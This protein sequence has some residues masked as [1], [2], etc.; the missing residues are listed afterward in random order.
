MPERALPDGALDGL[1]TEAAAR[2]GDRT[3]IRTT[4]PGAASPSFRELDAAATRC[5]AAVQGLIGTDGG[6]VAL[7]SPLD[8]AF[9]VAFHGI[10][11]SG[12]AVVPVNPL[13]RADELCHLLGTAR[14]RLA[15]VTPQ[16]LE[17][18]RSVRVR[19]P[20][21]AEVLVL[22]EEWPEGT[23]V[24]A[25]QPDGIACL[26]FT[27]GTTG[28]PKAAVLTHRNLLVNAAQTAAA[29]RLD[30]DAVVLNHLPKYHLMHLNSALSAGATQVLCAEPDSVDA[31]RAAN[32]HRATH[33]YSIPMRLTRLAADERLPQLGLDTVRMIA[34][35]GSALPPRS[36]E[37]LRRHF[38]VPVFQ[39]YGLAETSP[40]T[41]SDGPD[42][43]RPGSVGPPVEGTECRV[44]DIDTG[45]VLP[46]GS[47]GEVQVRGPQ[48]M[49]GY[50]SGPSPV[51]AE[52][53]LAT[54]D[55][56]V[57][58]ED[59]YLFLVDRIK[60]VFKCDNYLVSP[61]EVEKALRAHPAVRDCVVVDL[62]DP[63]SGAVA[64]AF[65]VLADPAAGTS[66]VLAQV[67]AGLPYYQRVRHAERTDAIP[68]AAGGKI[69]R[70]ELRAELIERRASVPPRQGGNTVSDS[71]EQ[72]VAITKF[73][74]R[75]EPAEFEQ[76][77]KEHAEFMRGRPGFQRAQMIRSARTP[78]VYVNV[79]YWTD[80]ASYLAVLQTDEFRGHL[81]LFAKLA[82]VEPL[83]GPVLF[84]L[85]PGQA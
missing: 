22:G 13:L 20:D 4:V 60:D 66:G 62:P 77:F 32:R 9:A 34:S 70:A 81:G 16:I 51:D 85:E 36:A 35:G 31:V 54:G 61:T 30:S 12:H 48:V 53:W 78:E 84:T 8:P 25:G 46:A 37:A 3:A 41:H 67:N 21:L 76:A 39:G 73:T 63:Y 40:L 44:V 52:G 71:V 11:R 65:L 5:A 47:R 2:Y 80:S 69:R 79:G 72:V 26:H 29:H 64:G 74:V 43:P 27:S 28:A 15:V 68:R 33:F 17:E 50:L 49:R 83:M 7:A 14:A 6:S 10:V 42:R 18:L 56:G 19:L 45:A 57:R 82:D 23:P 1:L 75:A 59:G 24:A 55:V 38:G 58:D